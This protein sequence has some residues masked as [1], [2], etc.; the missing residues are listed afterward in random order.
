MLTHRFDRYRDYQVAP[1]I[2]LRMDLQCELQRQ[3]LY[4]SL[5]NDWGRIF[6]SN[7]SYPL[8]YLRFIDGNNRCYDG[9][10]KLAVSCPELVYCEGLA[11]FTTKDG[12]VYPLGHAWCCTR[13]GDVVDPTMWMYQTCPSLVYYGIPLATG[14]ALDWFKQSGYHGILDGF[15]DGRSSILNEMPA[16]LWYVELDDDDD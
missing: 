6:H 1:G 3:E 14:I 8:K 9:A 7:K 4:E 10:A 12:T 2:K 15:E 11:L 16:M 5:L 13:M